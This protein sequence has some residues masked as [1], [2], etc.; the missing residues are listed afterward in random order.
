YKRKK[1]RDTAFIRVQL[2]ILQ[3]YLQKVLKGNFAVDINNL[4]GKALKAH[5][6]KLDAIVCAYTLVYC[7]KN[8]YTLYGD[9]FKVPKNIKLYI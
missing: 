1:G 3:N 6:D 2:N 5:E 8:P 9:I 4:K 7:E